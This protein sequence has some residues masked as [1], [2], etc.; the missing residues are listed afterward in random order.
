MSDSS[1]EVE[2]ELYE[3]E[4]TSAK[5]KNESDDFSKDADDIIDIIKEQELSEQDEEVEN[6][7]LLS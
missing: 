2:S 7:K 1:V 5:E 3:P 6:E 4:I